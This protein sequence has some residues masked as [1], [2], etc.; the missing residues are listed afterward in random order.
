MMIRWRELARPSI[1]RRILASFSTIVVVI[2][3]AGVINSIELSRLQ[4]VTQQIIPVSSQLTTIQD[5]ALTLEILDADLEQY[6]LVGD[7]ATRDDIFLQLS[8]LNT[9]IET[10]K[11][12]INTDLATSFDDLEATTATLN[13]TSTMLVNAIDD[14]SRTE[15]LNIEMLNVF[16][17]LDSAKEQSQDLSG[18]LLTQVQTTIN[19]QEQF[20]RQLAR[21]F[22]LLTGLVIVV[23][24]LAS[25]FVS[26]SVA[27]PLAEMATIATEV[28]GGNLNARVK[29]KSEDE[30]GQLAI[31]FNE[32][33][34]QVQSSL[35]DLESSN[36]E[37]KEVSRLKDE[38]LAIM[39][40]ELRTP[41]NA[42]IGFHGIMMMGGNLEEETLFMIQRSRANAERL[43]NLINDILDISRIESGR[44]QLVPSNLKIT[45]LVNNWESQMSILATEKG[46]EFDINVADNVP[47]LMYIDEDAITKI[48][49]NL[50]GNAFKFT[51]EGKVQLKVE[52]SDNSWIIAVQD[53]GEGIP[54][55]MQEIIFERFRQVDG[56]ST[57]KFGGSGLGL[58]I[59]RNLCLAMNG[60]IS[61][62]SVSGE[63]STFTVRLPIEVKQEDVVLKGVPA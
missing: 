12:N 8:D 19:E 39:S 47:D 38:F 63:G 51:D 34:D 7:V 13:D 14:D 22:L 10:L 58:A 45:E 28:A 43:L 29:V 61:L 35:S 24:V 44:F 18:S 50:L 4:Q 49:T 30:V 26:R 6:L 9:V 21:Q 55:H 33:T 40:H 53:S 62:D 32:M 56:S 52:Q 20:V 37:L 27:N 54:A 41:L 23:G 59:V 1:Y 2:L 60:N 11:N 17:A 57:R 15:S 48:V 16:D 25:V 3:V 36:R 31:A 42:I 46:L 5:Y